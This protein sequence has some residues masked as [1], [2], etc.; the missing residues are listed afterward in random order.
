[1]IILKRDNVD[2]SCLMAKFETQPSV[3]DCA[4]VLTSYYEAEHAHELATELVANDIV[5]VNDSASTT[6]ELEYV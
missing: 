1:M 4:E 2:G 6:F 3:S 5:D